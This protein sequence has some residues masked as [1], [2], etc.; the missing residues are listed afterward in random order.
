MS[1][2]PRLNDLNTERMVYYCQLESIKTQ[3]PYSKT[4]RVKKFS[5]PFMSYIGVQTEKYFLFEQSKEY[6]DR[7]DYVDQ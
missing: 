7:N 1:Y 2:K 6:C 3:S 4:V 5:F